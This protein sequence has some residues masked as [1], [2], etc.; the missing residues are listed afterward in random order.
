MSVLPPAGEV[1][2]LESRRMCA[3]RAHRGSRTWPDRTSLIPHLPATLAH[4]LNKTEVSRVDARSAA[5]R[6]SSS[7]TPFGDLMIERSAI[8]WA[9][10]SFVQYC[11]TSEEAPRLFNSSVSSFS[12]RLAGGAVGAWPLAEPL[13][14]RRA[15][16][17][18]AASSSATAFANATAS[19]GDDAT[20]RTPSLVRTSYRMVHGIS[21][22]RRMR[23]RFDRTSCNY[24]ERQELQTSPM[25]TRDPGFA[26]HPELSHFA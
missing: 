2:V 11:L 4:W 1:G 8:R 20:I 7:A 5:E 12:K 24:Q 18:E 19:A 14:A 23:H 16:F 13:T 15:F 6:I 25:T 17:C 10:F 3:A 22:H 21:Y 26:N 9:K